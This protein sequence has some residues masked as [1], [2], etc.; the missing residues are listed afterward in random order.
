MGWLNQYHYNVALEAAF[1]GS[2]QDPDAME[3]GSSGEQAAMPGMQEAAMT[4]QIV[5]P[6][7]SMG[8]MLREAEVS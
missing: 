7:N 2:S 3:S 1:R 4:S 6:I 5:Y 8:Q